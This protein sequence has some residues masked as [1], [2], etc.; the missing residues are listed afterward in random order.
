MAKSDKPDNTPKTA[1]E[2]LA[3]TWVNIGAREVGVNEADDDVVEALEAIDNEPK[4]GDVTKSNPFGAVTQ[5]PTF[6]TGHYAYVEDGEVVCKHC[7]RG[8][9]GAAYPDGSCDVCGPLI[10]ALLS[11]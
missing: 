5:L 7:G 11:E 8:V 4:P 9:P 6:D 10:E 2:L 3:A 1:H